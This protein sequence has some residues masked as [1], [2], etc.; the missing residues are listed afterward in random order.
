MLESG[1]RGPARAL[2]ILAVR[3]AVAVAI[4]LALAPAARAFDAGQAFRKNAFVLSL[5]GGYSQQFNR[6]GHT[7][8][9]ELESANAGLRLGWMPLGSVGQSFYRGALEVGLEPYYLQYFDPV[10]AYWAGL[11]AVGRWHFLPLGRFVPYVE[12]LAGVGAS[13]LDVVEINSN[14]S[15]MLAMGAGASVFL[16]QELA[17]YAGYRFLHYSNADLDSPNRGV[18]SHSVVVGVSYV[19]K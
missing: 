17:V 9:S 3:G 18:E 11:A 13:N 1:A 16:T 2:G 8:F 10:N 6:S 7:A 5:E 15:F 19:F 12:S 4:L 14:F